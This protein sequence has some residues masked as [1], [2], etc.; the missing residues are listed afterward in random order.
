VFYNPQTPRNN[1]VRRFLLRMAAIGLILYA[2]SPLRLQAQEQAADKASSSSPPAPP[3]N[4]Y[5]RFEPLRWKGLIVPIPGPA[6]TVDKRAFGLRDALADLGIG[7]FAYTVSYFTTNLAK[8]EGPV[9][10]NQLYSGQK[11][12]YNSANFAYLMF[13][14]SRYGVPDGQFVLGG[15]YDKTNWNPGGPNTLNLTVASYYQ[16]LFDKAVELK[17]GLFPNSVEFIGTYVGGNLAGGIFGSSASVTAE[18]GSSG[19]FFPAPGMN[20]K[21]NLPGN[22]YTKI[23]LQR[24]ISPDGV[25]TEH[26]QNPSGVRFRVPN[27]GFLVIDETGYRTAAAPGTRQTWLR[28]AGAF[29]TSA[30]RSYRE[31]GT[32]SKGDFALFLLGD[33]QVWQS[34][35]L[36][37]AAGQGIY[38]GFSAMYTPPHINRFSQYYELRLYGIGLIPGRPRDM[39]S[40]VGTRNV[41]SHYLVETAKQAGQLTNSESRAI[42]VSY[43]AVVIPGASLNVALGYTDN[44]TGVTYTPETGRALNLTIGTVIFL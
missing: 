31:P 13:D 28:L 8:H 30:Y 4:D 20:V 19:S 9:D 21:F 42:T 43:S 6:D 24:P 23:G 2:G 3:A 22:F 29:N 26:N 39:I 34:K 11:F 15:A 10:G 38:A 36:P 35:P 37:G 18:V 25:V 27:T 14:L 32:R 33:H 12:T 17:I 1:I 41:F 40:L 44:P 7:Y 16:T 5:S